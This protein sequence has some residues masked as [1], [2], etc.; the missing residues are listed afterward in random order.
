MPIWIID[1]SGDV[2]QFLLPLLVGLN[3]AQQRHALNFVGAL[4]T[5]TAKRKVLT[6]LTAMLRVAHADHY[7]LADFFRASPWDAVSVR[8]AV[9]KRVMQTV[10]ALQAQLG[11]PRVFL[12]I[13]D[14]LCR[15]D[16]ATRALEAVGF[17]FDHVAQRRQRGRYTNSSKYVTVCL[18]IGAWKFPLT[19]RLYLKH[20]QVRRLNRERRAVGLPPLVYHSLHDLV[21]EMLSEVA[22]LL[23]VDVQVYVLFDSWYAAKGLFLRIRARGWHWICRARS[24]RVLSDVPLCQWWTKLASQRVRPMRTHSTQGSHTYYTRLTRGR[25][26]RYPDEVVAVISKRT[27]RD[28]FPAYFLCSDRRLRAETIL[29]YYGFRWQSEVD[30]FLIKER[31]GLADYRVQS[32]RAISRWHTLVFAAYAFVAVRQAERWLAHPCSQPL[33]P[34]EVLDEQRRWHARNLVCYIAHRARQG[35]SDRQLLDEL[36]PT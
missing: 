2:C 26:R 28:R 21:H 14:A 17:F 15:K 29:K 1:H 31:F 5:C 3:A 11:E 36:M 7:A 30:N 20:D 16:M 10:M 22:P 25:L 23:P 35:C 33:S 4:L 12:S 24:N 9:L 8:E 13:D 19:W 27:R 34:S 32:F 6:V 18:R